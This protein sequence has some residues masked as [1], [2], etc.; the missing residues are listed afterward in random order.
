MFF[1]VAEN[2]QNNL[3]RIFHDAP[4]RRDTIKPIVW[5]SYKA[6]RQKIQGCHFTDGCIQINPSLY[7]LLHQNPPIANASQLL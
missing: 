5:T 4:C 7:R 2:S 3:Q 6:Y 1:I